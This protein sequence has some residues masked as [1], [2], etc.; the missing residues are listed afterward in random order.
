MALLF[1]DGFDCYASRDDFIAGG[2]AATSRDNHSFST[3]NGRFG[4]GCVQTNTGTNGFCRM[5][6]IANAGTFIIG[7]AFH[8]TSATATTA[9]N[10]ILSANVITD[11]VTTEA[12]SL[13]VNNTGDLFFFQLAAQRGATASAA[14]SVNTWHWIELKVVLQSG[15]T[16]SVEIRV[17][18]VSVM[19]VATVITSTAGMGLLNFWGADGD[20]RYDDIIVMD[21]T[22]SAPFN[23]FLGDSRID[24][25]YPTA[26]GG[27]VDWTANTGTPAQAVDDVPNAANDDTDYI[28]SDTAGEEAR[29]GFTN[30]GVSPN[31]IW[32][33]QLKVR[34]RKPGPGTRTWRGLI[35]SGD[36]KS[37]V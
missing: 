9:N 13:R 28:A 8:Y 37:V 23:D 18:G 32:G 19:T 16:G 25:L 11:G 34:G 24:T 29:F 10:K 22:G 35:N 7:F 33:V 3:S 26:A 31:N 2:W 6:R 27:V 36:R 17:D 5:A 15:A 30:L 14:L 12:W 1:A 21:G 4:G 20:S